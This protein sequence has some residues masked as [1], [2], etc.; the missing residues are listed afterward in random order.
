MWASWSLEVSLLA[1]CL[2]GRSHRRFRVVGLNA[3]V[4]KVGTARQ[5]YGQR[6]RPSG[7]GRRHSRKIRDRRGAWRGALEGVLE[8]GVEGLV[9]RGPLSR[10]LAGKSPKRVSGV[11]GALHE[12][13][14]ADSL[15]SL[16]LW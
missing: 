4:L 6:V 9:A 16:S 5:A 2:G 8:G 14:P 10:L 11:P 3:G 15:Q 13:L 1:R 12:R 7:S